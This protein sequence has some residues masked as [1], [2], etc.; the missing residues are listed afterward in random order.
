MLSPS[1]YTQ[2]VK[3]AVK[4]MVVE[5][6]KKQPNILQPRRKSLPKSFREHYIFTTLS[7]GVTACSDEGD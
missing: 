1:Y 2:R 6:K 3:K 4:N 5:T 7:S